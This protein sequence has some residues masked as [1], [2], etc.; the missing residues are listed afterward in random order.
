MLVLLGGVLGIITHLG[1]VLAM[2]G[3]HFLHSLDT[4]L[5]R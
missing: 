4:V 1:G 2:F 5:M 3:H